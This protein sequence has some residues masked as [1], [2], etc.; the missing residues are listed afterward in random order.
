MIR[1]S[2]SANAGSDPR[3]G[4]QDRFAVNQERKGPSPNPPLCG[5]YRPPAVLTRC[6]FA[7]GCRI[8]NSILF[9]IA[10]RGHR[11]A[12]SFCS[13]ELDCQSC[14]NSSISCRHMAID[15]LLPTISRYKTDHSSL[16]RS[17]DW[18]YSVFTRGPHGRLSDDRQYSKAGRSHVF[19]CRTNSFLQ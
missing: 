8:G 1:L 3:R 19:R 4:G 5:R 15:R 11:E 18:L 13:S 14:G 12:A 2:R 16:R 17:P 9:E 10:I 6:H 7:G